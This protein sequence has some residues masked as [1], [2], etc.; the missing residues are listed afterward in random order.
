M[1]SNDLVTLNT[2]CPFAAIRATPR[3]IVIVPRVTM[4]GGIFPY[5]T[6][7]PL[8]HPT[9]APITAERMIGTIN[10]YSPGCA[11]V[12]AITP[13]SATID[14][15]DRSIPPDTMTNIIPMARIPLMEA[16]LRMFTR[17]AGL[18]NAFGDRIINMI[19]MTK[20]AMMI[21]ISLKRRSLNSRA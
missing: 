13:V 2:G 9:N 1:D 4:N 15:T 6:L 3:M 5:A 17:L 11:K 12:A 20:N 14:P 10:G 19:N 8:K 16:C 21:P 18:A 7:A